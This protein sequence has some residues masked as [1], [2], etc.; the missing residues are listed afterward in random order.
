M[1]NHLQQFCDLQNRR[2]FIKQA[3]I[4]LG[5]AAASSFT[6]PA[7]GGFARR[8]PPSTESET[9]YLSFHGRRTKPT[10]SV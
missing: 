9:S 5:A 1:T 10:G 6:Q 7:S 3:G 2:Q 8:L 4:G